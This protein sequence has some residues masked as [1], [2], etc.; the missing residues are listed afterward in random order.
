ML[1]LAALLDFALAALHAGIIAAGAPA[2]R[3]FRAGNSYAL[4]A[5]SGER[6]PARNTAAIAA[7]FML[8]GLCAVS[9]AGLGPPVPFIDWGI[10]AIAAIFVA[11]GLALGPQLA[12]RR[13]FTAGQPVEQRDLL[14]STASLVIGSIHA[15]GLLGR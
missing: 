10:I 6:W 3:Y 15:A 4:A 1:L 14:F 8:W 9:A 13:V 5:E 12:G 7:V 2:Y 11:R